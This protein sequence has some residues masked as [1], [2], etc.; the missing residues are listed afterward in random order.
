[1]WVL[2]MSCIAS[3]WFIGV[4][5]LACFSLA[6]VSG[7]RKW[8]GF[9]GSLVLDAFTAVAYVP[10][11]VYASVVF[12]RFRKNRKLAEDGRAAIEKDAEF[13]A[14]SDREWTEGMDKE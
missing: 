3:A 8:T 13:D 11:L 6:E 12:A 2:V 5:V 9:Y 10:G 4:F 7:T 14:S 1:M